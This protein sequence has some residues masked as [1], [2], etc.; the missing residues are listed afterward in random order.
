MLHAHY[1]SN[2]VRKNGTARCVYAVYISKE[3][4]AELFHNAPQMHN[5]VVVGWYDKPKGEVCMRRAAASET[6]RQ[7]GTLTLVKGSSSPAWMKHTTTGM[8]LLN[9]TS[10][11]LHG[12]MGGADIDLPFLFKQREAT[13]VRVMNVKGVPH[14]VWKLP[15]RDEVEAPRMR[16]ANR[17]AL[18]NPEE[19]PSSDV[20]YVTVK[21][22]EN[23]AL[24]R[25]PIVNE[26]PAAVY[27]E[28]AADDG[29]RIGW[30]PGGAKEVGNGA[31]VRPPAPKTPGQAMS[32]VQQLKMTI[33]QVNVLAK[34]IG[35]V[36]LAIADGKLRASVVTTVDL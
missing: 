22:A 6:G 27:R 26:A 21:S 4:H 16:K 29:P 32:P 14:L 12:A 19:N 33:A 31:G 10:N 24:G 13:N 17:E 8:Y 1:M 3:Q 34:Q 18:Y 36:H 15:R 11:T 20:R 25:A 28:P 30:G 23:A 9:T 2:H 5:R 7:A 35:N